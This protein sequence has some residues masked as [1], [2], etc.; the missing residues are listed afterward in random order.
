MGESVSSILMQQAQWHDVLC[1]WSPLWAT[2]WRG[3]SRWPSERRIFTLLLFQ[4]E[5]D[6]QF[7]WKKYFFKTKFWTRKNHRA[8]VMSPLS[9][10]LPLTV[11]CLK[12]SSFIAQL[13]SINT[14]LKSTPC[15]QVIVGTYN[16]YLRLMVYFNMHNTLSN[17]LISY[18]K[19]WYYWYKKN[20]STPCLSF[21]FFLTIV[22]LP[23]MGTLGIVFDLLYY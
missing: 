10:S 11:S 21:F 13:R 17:I 22:T 5:R 18:Y 12:N 23:V 16:I 2:W 4:R 1:W 15:F 20:T 3:E 6:N 19:I 7:F 14:V 9:L 8:D